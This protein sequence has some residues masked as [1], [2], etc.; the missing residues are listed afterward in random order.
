MIDTSANN[1]GSELAAIKSGT[2]SPAN[3]RSANAVAAV[4]FAPTRTPSSAPNVLSGTRT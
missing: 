1:S 2:A 3:Q 4:P